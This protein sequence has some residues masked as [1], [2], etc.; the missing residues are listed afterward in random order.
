MKGVAVM[1]SDKLD[2]NLRVVICGVRDGRVTEDGTGEQVFENFAAARAV[3]PQLRLDGPSEGF[4]TLR[5]ESL[6]RPERRL[7]FETYKAFHL[8]SM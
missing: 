5:D 2:A 3:F 7:R 8:F 6:W 4:H 1:R